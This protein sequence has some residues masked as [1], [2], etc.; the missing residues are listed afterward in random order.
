MIVCELHGIWLFVAPSA[1]ARQTPLSMGILQA[2]ILERLTISS[3]RQS[4]WP[5]GGT[6]VSC[7]P[8][9]GRWVLYYSYHLGNPFLGYILCHFAGVPSQGLVPDDLRWSIRHLN[10][11]ESILRVHG[12]MSSWNWSLGPKRLGTTIMWGT[13]VN[14]ISWWYLFRS[15]LRI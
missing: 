11:P 4:S 6:R 12:K 15:K 1:V 7:I 14:F 13:V 9:S 5:R 2:R 10:H 8:F 3:S